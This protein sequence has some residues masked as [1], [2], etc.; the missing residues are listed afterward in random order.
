MDLVPNFHKKDLICSK[1]LDPDLTTKFR[2]W[3]D[4]DPQ[5]WSATHYLRFEYFF[6]FKH[7][8][9]YGSTR[10][11]REKPG[12]GNLQQYREMIRHIFDSQ[13]ERNN[14][15]ANYLPIYIFYWHP[16]EGKKRVLTSFIWR[17]SV[18]ITLTCLWF[19]DF[20]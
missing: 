14:I 5:H 11:A 18:K 2:S 13:R 8:I 3:P 1:R 20:H 16:A 4:L 7:F 9:F 6:F 19:A 12:P 10:A 17:D 15:I